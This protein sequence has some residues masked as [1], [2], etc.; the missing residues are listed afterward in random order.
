MLKYFVALKCQ[1]K[2]TFLPWCTLVEGYEGSIGPSGKL[3]RFLQTQKIMQHMH[4]N[5]L[6]VFYFLADLFVH[7]L[8]DFFQKVLNHL[9][10]IVIYHIVILPV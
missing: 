9:L 5:I 3:L 6:Y 7:V 10:Q 4:G 1:F 8:L 2:R